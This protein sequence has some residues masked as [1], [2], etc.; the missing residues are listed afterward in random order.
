M[1]GLEEIL[2]HRFYSG[3]S[4]CFV[5]VIFTEKL[6]LS[7]SASPAVMFWSYSQNYNISTLSRRPMLSPLTMRAGE[8]D[9]D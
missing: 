4:E 5:L 1:E 3:A 7:F 6:N 9:G 2:L 8:C